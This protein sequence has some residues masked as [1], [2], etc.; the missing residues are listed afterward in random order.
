[1]KVCAERLILIISC[2]M[3]LFFM[4]GCGNNE[5]EG[6]AAQSADVSASLEESIE[7]TAPVINEWCIDNSMIEAD[8]PGAAGIKAVWDPVAGADGYEYRFSFVWSDNTAVE[9]E[10][11][12]TQDTCAS[13]FFQDFG[14]F[15]IEVRAYNQNGGERLYSDW[16]RDELSYDEACSMLQQND[17]LQDPAENT[18]QS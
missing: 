10:A 1:M 14:G 5:A 7:L 4:A 3:L 18:S 16:S 9:Q 2:I 12:T 6:S 8:N 15:I 11:E 17:D 13:V